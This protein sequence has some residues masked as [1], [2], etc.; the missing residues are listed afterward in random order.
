[1]LSSSILRTSSGSA[2]GIKSI[3]E[4][5]QRHYIRKLREINELQQKMEDLQKLNRKARQDI[6]NKEIDLHRRKS[7]LNTLGNKTYEIRESLIKFEEVENEVKE[8][9]SEID[10]VQRKVN[11]NED[12]DQYYENLYSKLRERIEVLDERRKMARDILDTPIIGTDLDEVEIDHEIDETATIDIQNKFAIEPE[13]LTKEVQ[14]IDEMIINNEYR[15]KALLKRSSFLSKLTQN[16]AN[17]HDKS[18]KKEKRKIPSSTL[19]KEILVEIGDIDKEVNNMIRS[20]NKRKERLKK[21][22]LKTKVIESAYNRKKESIEEEFDRKSK[23]ISSYRSKL[24]EIEHTGMFTNELEQRNRNLRIQLKTI[25][26]Q[27]E[28]SRRKLENIIGERNGKNK[29]NNELL[30]QAHDIELKQRIIDEHE[31]VIRNR[32]AQV[33]KKR[34]EV[35]RLE[36][37][38]SE[39]EKEVLELELKTKELEQQN[40]ENQNRNR[41]LMIEV[42]QLRCQL[43]N[44]DISLLDDEE[45]TV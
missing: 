17:N 25:Q 43:A 42:D 16:I 26:D 14:A 3:E 29:I 35:S 32:R 12:D 45:N 6:F 19:S 7:C 9:K 15:R 31:E 20:V 4:D 24:Q 11:G 21:Y 10:L 39:R 40:A 2:D 33:D 37:M 5:V 44:A 18:V 38:T 30:K 36:L 23:T 1:M 27:S 8:L 34:N 13:E 22:K 41:I 28:R